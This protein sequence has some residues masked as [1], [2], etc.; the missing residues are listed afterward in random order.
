MTANAGLAVIVIDPAFTSRWGRE[1]WL[2]PLQDHSHPVP[3]SGHHAAA[4]VIGRRALGHRAR[5]RAGV[6]G[7]GQRTSRR[8]ATPRAPVARQTTRNGRPREAQRQ[9]PPLAEDRDGQPDQPARPGDPGPSG[10]AGDTGPYPAR[11]VGTVGELAGAC[12]RSTGRRDL[13]GERMNGT[14]ECAEVGALLGV[15]LT[16]AIAPGDRFVLTR[17]LAAC[18]QCRDELAGL[19]GLPGLL[20]R[21]LRPGAAEAWQAAEAEPG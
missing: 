2:A 16:G 15:Y 5:R 20:R 21:A 3:A 11:S 14:D 7:G 8:R 1:H 18:E 13:W 4:V 9:P 17:H 19:A 10:A 6:T 12:G